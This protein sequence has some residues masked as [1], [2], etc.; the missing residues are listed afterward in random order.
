MKNTEMRIDGKPLDPRN[1][2]GNDDQNSSRDPQSIPASA[3][4]D[5][6]PDKPRAEPESNSE[7]DKTVEEQVIEVLQD[8]YDPEIP[9]NIYELGLI[10][11]IDIDEANRVNIKMTLTS[12]ACPVAESLP[13]EVRTGVNKIP[14]VMGCD[15]DL[16]WE[17]PWGPDRMSEV[18]KMKLGML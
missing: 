13:I 11:E 5:T 1:D 12:P 10:Y 15:I 18:A 14:Q 4:P 16:V 8:V 7:K 6:T 17:P 3:T 9:V 2:A